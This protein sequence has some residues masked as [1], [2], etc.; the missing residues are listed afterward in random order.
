MSD[1][2]LADLRLAFSYPILRGFP[3]LPRTTRV[4]GLIETYGSALGTADF[5]RRRFKNQKPQPHD[6]PRRQIAV[7]QP[8]VARVSPAAAVSLAADDDIATSVLLRHRG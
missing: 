1:K 3:V 5:D 4:T 7:Q 6:K 2:V 8:I